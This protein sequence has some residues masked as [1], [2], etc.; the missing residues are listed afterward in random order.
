MM[1]GGL[2]WTDFRQI[3]AFGGYA[4]KTIE[5]LAHEGGM[6]RNRYAFDPVI[7]EPYFQRLVRSH[8]IPVMWS[9]GVREVQTRDRSI[10]MMHTTDGQQFAGRTYID[11]SYEGD[12]LDRAGISS[13]VGR[14]AASA[15][16]PLDGY[17]GLLATDRASDDNFL[18]KNRSIHVD[19][20]LIP[21]DAGSGLLQTVGYAKNRQVGSAD[22][23]IQAYGF[24]LTMT[25]NPEFRQDMPSSPPTGYRK[26]DFELL[27]RYIAAL[28]A[29]G[30][31]H[32][33]DWTFKEELIRPQEIAPGIYDVNNHGAVSTDAVGMSWDYPRASYTERERIWKAHDAYTR[34]FFYA[35]AWERDTRLPA[36]LQQ[37]VRN[38]GFVKGHYT[39]PAPGDE[40]GWPYQLYVPEAR[41]LDNGLEWSGEDLSRP[42]NAPLRQGNGGAMASNMQHS[43]VVQRIAV[44]DPKVG[45]TVRNEGQLAAPTGG[46]DSR[47]PLPF[48]LMVP[49][50]SQCTNLLASFCVASSH[51]A[52][53][54]IRMELT[55]MAMGEAAGAAAAMAVA[56][57]TTIGFQAIDLKALQSLLIAN[58]SVLNE[59]STLDRRV[60][61]AEYQTRRFFA[62]L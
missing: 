11:A 24:R 62:R 51:Q 23:G 60:R 58:G 17:R 32:G 41:R 35:L 2:G 19:P 18:V 45:W 37:E 38:W 59:V 3:D 7:A 10:V 34:G 54:C 44:N 40:A 13:H 47:S 61:A 21:G 55:S 26:A 27:F 5:A 1:T 8:G 57:R 52:F 56:P 20:F 15:A 50:E 36:S 29:Q 39:N 33:S 12:L 43:Q 4:R 14:E 6:P 30:L 49:H 31:H 53:S 46:D 42:D 9:Q 22:D 25:E 48:E 28:E 16:N